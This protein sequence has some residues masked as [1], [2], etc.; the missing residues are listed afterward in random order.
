MVTLYVYLKEDPEQPGKQ[1]SY[2]FVCYGMYTYTSLPLQVT[3]NNDHVL[4][5]DRK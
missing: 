5:S 1:L 2:I 4:T 3:R